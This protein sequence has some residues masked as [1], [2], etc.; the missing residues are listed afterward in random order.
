VSQ[1]KVVAYIVR[2]DSLVAFVH[3]NDENPLLDSGLQVPAG[4]VHDGEEPGAAVLREAF[5]ETG[6][7]GLRIV[8]RLGTDEVSWPD[9]PRHFRHFFH[10]TTADAPAQWRHV[11][12]DGGTGVAKPFRLF[13]LPRSKAALLAAAQGVFVARIDEAE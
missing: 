3:E 6:L 5:E 12:D 11:E 8:R 13:W 10:L 2:G 4:T 7:R 1:H 9:R